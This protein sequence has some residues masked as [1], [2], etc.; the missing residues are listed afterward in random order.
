[1]YRVLNL[2]LGL[3]LFSLV[4][5]IFDAIIGF[6]HN[7]G[8]DVRS[9]LRFQRV[10]SSLPSYLVLPF[11][12]KLCFLNRTVDFNGSAAI[13][14]FWQVACLTSVIGTA[15]RVMDLQLCKY[16]CFYFYF[17]SIWADSNQR[18]TVECGILYL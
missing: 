2:K 11:L 6:S 15:P 3:K 8:F 17:Y 13:S 18:E 4:S 9:R 10:E 1:M 12:R 16:I 5:P 14:S 7:I